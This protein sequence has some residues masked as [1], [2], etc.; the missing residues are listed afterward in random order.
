MSGSFFEVFRIFLKLGLTSFG[1]PTAHLVFFREE[2]VARRRWVDERAYADLVALCQFLPGPASSQTGFALGISRAGLRG[3]LAAWLGFT[4]PSAIALGLFAYGFDALQNSAGE[5]GLAGLRVAAAA[6]VAR[7]VWGM[8]KSHS[9]DLRRAA[10]TL[11][12]AVGVLIIPWAGGQILVIL[13]GGFLGWTLLTAKENAFSRPLPFR[14]GVPLGIFCLLLFFALLFALPLLARLYPSPPLLLF[15]SFFR[16]GSLVF[17]GGHVVLP[18]LRAEVVPPGW[19]SDAQFLAGYGAAQAIPGPLFT[20][21]AYL[22]AAMQ[23]PMGG[24]GAAALCLAAI[25]APSALMVVGALP[26]W[27]ALRGTVWVQPALQGVN[28]AVVGLLLAAL[29]HP[30][31]TSA[32]HRPA[33]FALALAALGLLF[34][35][36]PPWA[37]VALAA[38]GG[39]A[40]KAL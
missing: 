23:E 38:L 22:G 39:W 33:D 34:R 6:V 32:L 9:P 12:S 26:F 28:A 14:V 24:L 37:V 15:D 20:F 17:G 19:V 31:S 7:A 3:G 11:L 40:L 30:I 27:E 10:I 16:A 36:W 5:G 1:G 25:F 2:L 8:A 18:L 4:L 29:Y 21:S 13:G 35:G